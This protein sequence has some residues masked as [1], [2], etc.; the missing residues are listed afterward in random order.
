[1]ITVRETLPQDIDAAAAVLEDGRTALHGR[2]IPQWQ[3]GYPNRTTVEADV[4]AGTGYVAVDEQGNVV[5]TLAFLLEAEPDY[6]AHPEL[7]L[8]PAIEPG[9]DA[10]Y[11]C[12]HRCAVAATAARKGV[13]TAMFD[14]M[15]NL[16]R[17]AGRTS[18]RADTHEQNAPMRTFLERRGYAERGSFDIT[19]AGTGGGEPDP[20]RIGYEKLL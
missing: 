2:G 4:C 9:K 16:A 5:G 13:M 12:I 8:T 17:K 14:A 3:A 7:W 11:A 19:A 15:E 1:M 18:M 6:E 10:A 20:R